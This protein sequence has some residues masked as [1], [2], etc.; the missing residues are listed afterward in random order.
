ML[1]FKE[2]LK[3]QQAKAKKQ[4]DQQVKDIGSKG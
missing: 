3:Q 2:W 1:R 4:Q